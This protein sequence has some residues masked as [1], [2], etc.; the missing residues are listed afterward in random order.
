MDSNLD[1]SSSQVQSL[2]AEQSSF[3]ELLETRRMPRSIQAGV[4][5]TAKHRKLHYIM[6]MFFLIIIHYKSQIVVSTAEAC[7]GLWHRWVCDS[8]CYK[9]PLG[10]GLASHL[11]NIHVSTE[12]RVDGPNTTS[13]KQLYVM[14]MTSIYKNSGQLLLRK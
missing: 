2:S 7:H 4:F 1:L 5:L 14:K 8:S 9:I 10:D 12:V 11:Q 13:V 3:Q 6:R